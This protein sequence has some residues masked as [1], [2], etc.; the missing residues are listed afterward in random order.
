MRRCGRR[1]TSDIRDLVYRWDPADRRPPSERRRALFDFMYQTYDSL[2][3]D[4]AVA[5]RRQ[6][7][8]AGGRRRRRHDRRREGRPR[9]VARQR[10][11]A[12]VSAW[13]PSARSRRVAAAMDGQLPRLS[14]GGDRRRGLLRRGHQNVRRTVARRGAQAADERARGARLSPRAPA[15]R[16]LVADANRI[17]TSHHHD[18]IDS[19][20][21]ARSTA[22]AASHVE[23]YMRPH[24]GAMPGVD[25]V[26][27]GDVK[28]PPL[29]HTA[30]KMPVGPLVHR[31]Q[32]S[33]SLSA[34]G[35]VD[36]AREGP[37][38]RR[39]RRVVVPDNQG[40]V[41]LGDP[42]SPAA[43]VPVRDR[44]GAGRARARAVLLAGDGMLPMSRGV[45]RPGQRRVARR[46]TPTWARTAPASTSSPTSSSTRSTQSPLA[47]EGALVE[48]PWICRDAAD[49]RLG[50]LSRTCTTGACRRCIICSGP[51]SERPAIF[52]VMAAG[53]FDR[54]ARR[55]A[56]LVD[57]AHGRLG[58]GQLLRRFGDDRD[59]F[60]TA[61]PGSAQRRATTS[62]RGFARMRTGAR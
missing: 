37:A 12:G 47:S 2:S 43:A 4:P 14:H 27:R 40:G 38:V 28:T 22:F 54:D 52:Q 39:A 51:V 8:D 1:S 57:P 26:G 41:R 19:L 49:R 5:V 9:A 34:D 50:Q 33:R 17:L 7:G 56:A 46:R 23:M 18:K 15:D 31:R 30:A 6:P 62:G 29:W 53:R 16:A 45:R 11:R 10:A 42:A 61:R 36:G 25:E 59:W 55:P 20:T 3:V 58:E 60:N 48:E 24:N 35:L 13:R 32:L 44:R 21:R